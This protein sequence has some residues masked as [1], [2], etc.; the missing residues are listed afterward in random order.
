MTADQLI[1]ALELPPDTRLDRRVSRELLIQQAARTSGD[2]KLLRTRVRE[3]VLVAMLK[4]ETVAIPAY[5]DDVREYLEI[6][7]MS[8][9]AD[10]AAPVGRVLQLIHRAVPYPALLIVE[11]DGRLH[12]SVAHKRWSQSESEAWV[13]EGDVVTTEPATPADDSHSVIGA[14]ALPRQPRSSMLGLYQGW[15]DTLIAQ[16]IA[17]ETGRPFRAYTDSE[18]ALRRREAL[19]NYLRISAQIDQLRRSA[20]RERQTPRLV[21][22]NL[23]IRRLEAVRADTMKLL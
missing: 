8:L 15:T 10:N 19:R 2:R 16:I 20:A 22:M 12:F 18:D 3:L 23:E 9:R 1:D 21:E 14:M 13:L 11:H 7:V 5:R 6:A 4:P 17:R